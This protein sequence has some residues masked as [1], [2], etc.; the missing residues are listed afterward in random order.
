MLEIKLKGNPIHTLGKIPGL[1]TQAP[2]FTLTGADLQEVHLKDY[3]GKTLVLN[4]FPSIDT[5]VC[6]MSVRKFNA[7]AAKHPEVKVL[8][9]SADLPFASARFC[10]AEGL[11]DVVTLSSFRNPEFGEKY[12]VRII[13]GPLKGLLSRAVVILDKEGKIKYTQQVPEITQEPDY[14]D[15]LKNL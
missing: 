8:C 7:E 9:I 5:A 10:G 13:D 3:L 6:A 12:Q 1:G 2:D 11:K 15:A 14:E 4:I